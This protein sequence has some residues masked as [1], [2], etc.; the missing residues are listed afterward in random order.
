M[1]FAIVMPQLGLT[2]EE[3]TVSGWLKKTGDAVKKNEPLFSVSTDKVEMDVE[4][5]V[6]GTLGKIIVP[7]GETVKVGTVLAYV[8]G[9][10][11]ED[12]TAV[13]SEQPSEETLEEAST[14]PEA[15][16]SK[17][18]AT[19]RATEPASAD[20]ASDGRAASPRAVSPRA[21]RLA[22][23]LGVDLATVRGTGVDG[24]ISEKD[25][26]SAAASVK[27]V[28]SPDGGRRQLIAEKL[29][30]SVQTI[31]T[32]SVAAEMNAENLIALHE[33]FKPSL[34][35]SGGMK[36]TLT[37]LL[38]MLF[39]QAFKSN[40]EL[41]ATWEGNTVSSRSSVDLGLAVATPKG[42]VAP[43]I[44]N[45]GSVDLRTL[46]TRRTEL[47]EKARAGRLSLAD[48]EG[49]VA[50]LS[51]LG[52]YRVDQFQAII[53]PGQSSILAVGQIRKRPWVE[54][55]LTVKPTVML[56]LTVDHRVTDGA[57]GA[58]FLSKLVDLIENPQGF[59]WQ[60]TT[61]SGDGAG[62]RSNA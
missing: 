13:G 22:K 10:D 15:P 39:A 30:L 59:S 17:A 60:P 16:A 36:I 48:L 5:A 62:R 37:D 21:K 42:V 4:S 43:V 58:A 49:G 55:T 6:D 23:E 31:P 8:D 32:F 25:I 29:T 24:Q 11:G 18:S 9:G 28:S 14:V 40:P 44:R 12:I 57:T 53:T 19:A 47:V 34:A 2:M 38:L 41:N 45:L 1:S 27:K 54:E 3:G 33:S 52:M 50:T 26:Q 61:A 46:V 20:R 51:N 56:N 7:A 35:Q